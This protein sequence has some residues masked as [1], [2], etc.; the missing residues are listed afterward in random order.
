VN[1]GQAF[2]KLTHYRA[3]LDLHGAGLRDAR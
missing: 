3:S 2:S 1:E